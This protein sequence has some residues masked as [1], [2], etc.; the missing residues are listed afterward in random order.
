M[1]NASLVTPEPGK[2][3]MRKLTHELVQSLPADGRDRIIFDAG[4]EGFGIRVTAAG[5]K[6][7]IAQAR[8][9]GRILRSA[10]GT[11]P[12]MTVR[13]AREEALAVRAAIRRGEDP[14]A[15]R[16]ARIKA[17]E[18]GAITVSAFTD[19]WLVE[20]VR[21]KLKRRTIADYERLLEQ[22]IKPALGHL[23]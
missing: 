19:R 23:L 6:I 4:T 9:G 21:P 8:M 5:R 20:Y 15:E 11:F 12:E 3:F 7:F 22:K 2:R 14:R 13:R 1:A 17:I 16:A 18:A 10:V